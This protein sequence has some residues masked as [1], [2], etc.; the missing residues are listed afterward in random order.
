MHTQDHE[1][2]VLVYLPRVALGI[3]LVTVSRSTTRGPA[4][5]PKASPSAAPRGWLL[6][7][8]AW[9][10][11]PPAGTSLSTSPVLPNGTPVKLTRA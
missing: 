4:V 6:N 2:L 1:H 11:R 8:P 3:K 7:G 10:Y 5:Q 9:A